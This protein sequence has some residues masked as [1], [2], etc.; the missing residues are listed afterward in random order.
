MFRFNPIPILPPGSKT[1]KLDVKGCVLL[2]P[3]TPVINDRCTRPLPLFRLRAYALQYLGR[4]GN[5]RL[6]EIWQGRD[7]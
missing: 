3:A 4:G 2:D 7:N 6:T 5:K 1:L